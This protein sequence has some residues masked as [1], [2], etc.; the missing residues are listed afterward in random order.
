[1]LLVLIRRRRP[2]VWCEMRSR[3]VS[4]MIWAQAATS[5]CVSSPKGRWITWD[6]MMWLI[7]KASGKGRLCVCTVDNASTVVAWHAD[8]ERGSNDTICI[9][10]WIWVTVI[11]VV[12]C[13]HWILNAKLIHALMFPLREDIIDGHA[14]WVILCVFK[15]KN[16]HRD[17]KVTYVCITNQAVE[18]TLFVFVFSLSFL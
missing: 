5:I 18:K 7:R 4:S 16:S 12:T 8:D 13:G 15:N 17:V 1:M 6:H 10:N 14:V 9:I 3:P 2:R 11:F